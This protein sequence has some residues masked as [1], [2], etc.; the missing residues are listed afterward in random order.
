[1]FKFI[2]VILNLFFFVSF[3]STKT[4]TKETGNQS[5][6]GKGLVCTNSFL[7]PYTNDYELD[8]NKPQTKK[9]YY[10]VDRN[11][12]KVFRIKG[13]DINSYRR[14]YTLHKTDEVRINGDI[15][16]D[17]ETL[18]ARIGWFGSTYLCEG[19]GSERKVLSI[20]END[21]EEGMRKN[22]F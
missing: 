12:V 11:S 22:K 13:N 3:F 1:M 4:Y 9:Y 5:V 2:F 17:R 20:I 7:N 16:L 6:V 8:P 10:F 19:Y 14:D 21:I 18:K 15:T